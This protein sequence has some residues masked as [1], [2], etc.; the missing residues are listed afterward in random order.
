V[1]EKALVVAPDVRVADVAK[2]GQEGGGRGHRGQLPLPHLQMHIRQNLQSKWCSILP[3]G[4]LTFFATE[5]EE[6]DGAH[7]MQDVNVLSNQFKTKTK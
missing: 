6:D 5:D 4:Y 3:H 2:Q 1:E 7:K